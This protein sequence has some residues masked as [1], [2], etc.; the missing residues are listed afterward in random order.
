M[1]YFFYLLSVLLF[2]SCSDNGEDTT[3]EETKPSIGVFTTAPVANAVVYDAQNQIAT[4]DPSTKRY[5]FDNSITYPVT[6]TTNKNTY[7]DV[8]YDG[9]KTAADLQPNTVYSQNGLKSFCQEVNILTDLYYS[10]NYAD[11]NITIKQYKNEIALDYGIDICADA[12]KNE[13]NAKTLFGAY[14]FIINDGNLTKT[15]DIQSEVSKID[16]FFTLYMSSLSVDKIKYYSFYNALLALDA[17]KVTRSDTIHKPNIPSVMR[18]EASMQNSFSDL[19]VRDLFSDSYNLYAAAAHD[20]FA[21]L[22]KSLTS[23]TFYGTGDVDAF[24]LSLYYQKYNNTSCLFLANKNDGILPFKLT[25]SGAQQQSRIYKYLDGNA[26]EQN[27]S[28]AGVIALNGFVSISGNKRFLG[29][30]T[31][32]KG[33][34]LIDVKNI[35]SDC[36]LS[37]DINSSTILI[38]NS[39]GYSVSSLFREDGSFVYVANKEDGLTRYELTTPTQADINSSKTLF[40]LQNGAEAY[41][42]AFYPNSNEL[43]VTTNQGLQLYDV[44]NDENLTFT[45]SYKTEGSKNDYIQQVKIADRFVVLSDGTK[46]V[47]ILQLDSSYTPIL[48][49]VEYFAD[50]NDPSS[51]QKTTAL[52]YD[53][54]RLYIGLESGGIVNYRLEDLLFRHCK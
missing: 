32:D 29:I 2:T 25:S 14:N 47:K 33:Y 40:T 16:D 53:Q 26:T 20:E 5:Y 41:N 4:Y 46:G 11:A 54:G 1:R 9:K 39:S 35:F 51:V 23:R 27:L 50:P 13:K 37:R 49:G 24:G 3:S 34:Y 18:E 52:L 30:S 15:E 38:Q 43:L 12:T 21:Q 45:S 36:N 48:C 8:D 44:T 10:A 22:D 6:V 19:D 31:Q 28:D 7:I 42:L 17:Q